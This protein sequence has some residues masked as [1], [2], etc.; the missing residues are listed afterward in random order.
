[1]FVCEHFA[2]YFFVFNNVAINLKKKC[3]NYKYEQLFKLYL[4]N[5]FTAY[6]VIF[7]NY[8]LQILK[9]LKQGVCVNVKLMGMFSQSVECLF[10]CF[11]LIVASKKHNR[12]IQ[13]KN[14]SNLDILWQQNK[15]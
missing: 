8:D 12:K 4:T 2:S 14:L 3:V 1:M 15:K 5:Y 6:G 7:K 13:K 10:I 9:Q 11:L